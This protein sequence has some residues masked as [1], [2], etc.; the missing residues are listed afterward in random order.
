MESYTHTET[1]PAYGWLALAALATALLMMAAFFVLPAMQLSDD[2][3]YNAASTLAMTYNLR[4][5][6]IVPLLCVTPALWSRCAFRVRPWTLGVLTVWA[7]VTAFGM[8]KDAL[9]AL[10][11]TLLIAPVGL[12][13]YGMQRR[14][15]SNFSTVFYSSVAL[16]GGLFLWIGLKARITDGDAFLPLRAYA[17]AVERTTNELIAMLGLPEEQVANSELAR[18]KDMLI[19]MKL[20]PET[21]LIE[22][23]YYPAALAALANGLLSHLFNRNKRV[24]L[25]PLPPFGEWQV[26]APYFYGTLVLSVIAFFL[27]AAGVR[28]GSGLLSAAYAMWLLPM[29]LAG[30]NVIKRMSKGRPW[31]FAL[32]CICTGLFFSM[33]TMLLAT[34]GMLGF[35]RAQMRK[36]MEERK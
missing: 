21:Y 28:Y 34:I 17:G 25:R 10:S 31:L 8:T 7:Y 27:S 12:L 35:M 16:L 24:E 15:A 1:K 36:R 9:S 18:V 20:Y 14:K 32:V 5:F 22:L 19:D 30:L 29:A 2:A 13:L 6:F 33:A 4:V 3:D 23:L 11:G 26:E